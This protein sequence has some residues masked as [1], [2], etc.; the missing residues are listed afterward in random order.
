MKQ[1][2]CS[3]AAQQVL[4]GHTDLYITRLGLGTVPLG[5]K[6]QPMS[7]EQAWQTIRAALEIGIN[8]GFVQLRPCSSQRSRSR[9]PNRSHLRAL[10]C[11]AACGRAPV[12]PGTPGGDC[13]VVGAG[14]RDEVQANVAALDTAIPADFWAELRAAGL[15]HPAAPTP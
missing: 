6:Y 2:R 5:G 1:D 7:S 3:Q 12:S 8:L 14:S 15:L 4:L 13:I 9:G 11:A 10:R